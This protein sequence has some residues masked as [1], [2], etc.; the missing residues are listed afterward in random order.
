MDMGSYI[1]EH[2]EDIRL[3]RPDPFGRAITLFAFLILLVMG[4]I[5]AIGALLV[6]KFIMNRDSH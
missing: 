1:E 5:I 2:E 3:E 6:K 4:I